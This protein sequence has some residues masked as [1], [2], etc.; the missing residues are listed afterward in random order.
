MG[1]ALEQ[2]AFEFVTKQGDSLTVAGQAGLGELGSLA[3]T[4]DSG[5]VFRARAEAAL[6]MSAIEKL[7]ETS[8]TA[9]VE[10][11]DAFG[12][13]EFMSGERKQIHV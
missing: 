1:E 11:A 6:V 9:D 4:Y 3:K 7:A 2:A 8:S 12:G 13:V 10:S 5:D